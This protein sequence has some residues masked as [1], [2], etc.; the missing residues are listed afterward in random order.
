MIQ[1]FVRKVFMGKWSFGE[2]NVKSKPLDILKICLLRKRPKQPRTS[3]E[4]KCLEQEY[5]EQVSS[6]SRE[7]KET[8]TSIM[9]SNGY[10]PKTLAH[11]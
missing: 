5:C 11:N 10:M 7:S 9:R 4:D 3:A 2:M 6:T 1:F 8:I